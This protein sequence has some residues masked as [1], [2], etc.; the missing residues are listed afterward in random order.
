MKVLVANRGEIAV[1]I[2]R[3]CRNHGI[4]TVAVYSEV[5]RAEQ[6]VRMADQAVPIGPPEPAKS[7][8]AIDR[9]VAAAK[10]SGADAIHPGYGFLSENAAFAQAVTDAGITFIGPSADSIRRMGDKILAR[11]AM[12][13]AG[14]PVVPGTLEPLSDA[15]EAGRTADEM[16]YPVMLK[17]VGGG[18]GKGIR[19]VKSADEIKS[20]FERASSEALNAF[21]NGAMYIEKYLANPRHIEV[22]ILADSHGNCIHYGERECSIQR[23]HQK[24]V[25]EAPSAVITPE[26]RAEMG[27]VAVRA[28]KAIGYVNA[29]T[30]EFLM[31]ESGDFYF[32]EMNTRLQVE[33][34]VTEIVYR[35]DLVREQLRIAA[36]EKLLHTQEDVRGVGHAIEVRVYAEDP[37]SNFLPSAGRI[38]HLEL[39][40][41]PGVRLDTNLYEGQEISLYYDPILGKLITFGSS[42]ASAIRR[43]VQALREFSVTGIKTTIPFLLRVL[44]HPKFLSG[45]FD[46]N[47]IDRHMA[48]LESEGEGLQKI[49][50]AIAAVLWS[51]ERARARK[52]AATTGNG[53][54]ASPWT[55]AGRRAATGRGG[56]GR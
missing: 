33:H 13:A 23:R 27:A 21:G 20:A 36:G 45:E 16:G 7:Y 31:D 2:I 15:D 3:G 5:D 38:E 29:G 54:G 11:Q 43:L 24:V 17:A 46:T 50:A 12:E 35:V 32:L 53:G 41:G 48:D 40:G 37:Q 6:H 39:P 52:P 4:E 9:I 26:V 14:V 30:C 49:P 51:R 55:L 18:G 42:R 1:R 56:T 34:P 19:V 10:Q 44:K 28:A 22:Q 8:L 25:E 47:F